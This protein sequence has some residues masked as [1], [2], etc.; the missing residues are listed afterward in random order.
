M[1]PR[2]FSIQTLEAWKR[3]KHVG[4]RWAL[5]RPAP[6]HG[7]DVT[8]KPLYSFCSMKKINTADLWIRYIEIQI[9]RMRKC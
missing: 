9:H 6:C 1:I 3:E 4:Y 8:L 5:R 2:V 7:V